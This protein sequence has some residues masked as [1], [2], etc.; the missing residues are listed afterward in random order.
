MMRRILLALSAIALIWA[1]L[2]YAHEDEEIEEIIVRGRWDRP[3][4][5]LISA[6]QGIV[7]QD[8]IDLRPRLRTGDMLEV[9]PGLVVTQH[10]GSGKSNQMFLRGF[11]LDHGTD[12]ATWIDG[13]P[14]NMPTH[15][16]GQ[17]Y[18]DLNFIIPELVDHVEY[19]LGSYY[20]EIGDF[21][22]AGGA[23][24]RLRRS[25][26]RGLFTAGLGENGFQR[27][28]AA[29]PAKLA[30]TLVLHVDTGNA[31]LDDAIIGTG[32]VPVVTGYRRKRLVKIES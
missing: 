11:N 26:D 22:S 29:T 30:R 3:I 24:V 9:V 23:H 6:S 8:E 17:G 14:V 28:V 16:H 1:D 18:T 5:M 20:A 13:M 7:S 31:N 32:Y 2:G 4:G 12:F 10:S 21:S 27:I 25:L 19:S 15:G